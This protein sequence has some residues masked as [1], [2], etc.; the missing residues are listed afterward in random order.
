MTDSKFQPGSLVRDN[1]LRVGKVVGGSEAVVIGGE[2]VNV[3]TV[4]FWGEEQKRPEQFLNPLDG[5]SPEALLWNR[6]ED[7]ESWAG[8]APL[9]LVAL[10]LSANGGSGKL[11]DIRLKL[12]DRI[13]GLV[14]DGWWRGVPAQMRKL[15][16]HFRINRVGKDNE[17]SLLTSVDKIPNANALKSAGAPKKVPAKSADWKGWLESATHDPLPSRFPTK[18][19]ADSIAGWAV[20]WSPETTEQALL[21]LITSAEEL[22]ATRD[23]S[24]QVAEGW[25]RAVAQTALRWREV[26]GSDPRGY[27]AARVGEVLARLARIAGDRTPQDLLLRAGAIGSD[28]DS[29]RRGFLAGIWES[30]EGEDAR[31]MY[32]SSAAL[33]GRQ[34]RADLAKEMFLAAFGPDFSQRRYSELDRLLDTLTEEHRAQLLREIVASATVA[35]MGGVLDYVAQSRHSSGSDNLALRLV[36][37]L[38]LKDEQ[39]EFAKRTSTELAKA[40]DDPQRLEIP[41]EATFSAVVSKIEE[42]G[43]SAKAAAQVRSAEAQAQVEQERREQERLRQQVRER[44]AE[45][46][47]SRLESRLEIRQDMLLAIGEVLQ[48]IFHR[49]G[50]GELAGDVAAGLSLALR[51]GDAEPLGSPGEAVEYNPE[52]HQLDKGAPGSGLVRIVAP[53]VVY[54]S[55]SRGDRVLLKAQVKHEAGQWKS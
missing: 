39:G 22:S 29:W 16:E 32:L 36:A 6:P 20:R 21:R 5:D 8:E 18:Q 13:P 38:T 43:L 26:G 41:F 23:A 3:L 53:G 12:D 11:A 28:T 51:A 49:N 19:T 25:L 35:Q 1:R 48:S 42:A 4:D 17:Y 45:L 10:A 15:P 33:L 52:L 47:A 31:D 9:K 54:R 50:S 30:F 46:A 44:N 40:L 2:S 7:L 14:W 27:T 34:A 55:G 24:A 37:A